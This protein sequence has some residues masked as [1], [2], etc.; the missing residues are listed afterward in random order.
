[1]PT[2]DSAGN[3]YFLS[4]VTRIADL[5]EQA[6]EVNALPRSDWGMGDYVV[7]RVTGVPEFAVQGRAGEWAHGGRA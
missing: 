2:T 1:M 5:A 3:R 7:G 4:S 6:F